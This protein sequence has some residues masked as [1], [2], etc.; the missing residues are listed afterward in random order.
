VDNALGTA[1]IIS[2]IGITLLFLSLILFYGIISLLTAVTRDKPATTPRRTDNSE[3]QRD[4]PGRRALQAAAIAIAL[5]RAEAEGEAGK[6]S[7]SI[8]LA[9]GDRNVTSWWSLHHQHRLAGKGK[10]R[11][12]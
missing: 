8:S 4:E 9:S 10:S 3:E 5:A 7:A 2:A 11:R 1:L 6:A 12:P